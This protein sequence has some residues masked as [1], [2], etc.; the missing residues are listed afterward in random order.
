MSHALDD[1]LTDGREAASRHAWREAYDLLAAA[2]ASGDLT[3]D[4]LT[5]LAEAAW[6]S[7]RLDEAIEHRERAYA[8][9]SDAGERKRAAMVALALFQ[10]FMG[11]GSASSGNGWFGRAERLLEDEPDSVEQGHLSLARTFRAAVMGN[12]PAAIVAADAAYESGGRY[13]DRD[14]Q[15]MALVL[16]GHAL[17]MSGEVSK[18]LALLDEA[19]AAAVSGELDPMSTGLIYCCTIASCQS[20]GDYGRAAEWTVEANRWC[21]RLDLKGFPGACR[22]HRAEL[23]RLKGDWPQAEEQAIQACEELQ[24]FEVSVTAAGFYEIGEIRRRRGD[25]AAAEEAYRKANELGRPP[26]PGL[27][28]LRLEQ[29]K[30]G[31]AAAAIRRTLGEDL[32]PL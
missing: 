4:D 11:K 30:V 18:G 19:T 21:D 14:L 1:P 22:V 15:G 13:G 3:P 29:G 23:L 24:D 2:A 32:D 6:W 20:V 12:L 31:A 5:A 28:L 27:A 10:D 26:Q 9:Y 8:G 16:K 7:G 17:V 25:F